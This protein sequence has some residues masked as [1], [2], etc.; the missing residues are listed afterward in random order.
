MCVFG[1]FCVVERGGVLAACVN[2]DSIFLN[3]H[4]YHLQHN[5]AKDISLT[6]PYVPNMMQTPC[7]QIRLSGI[8]FQ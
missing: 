1:V 5:Y 8:I 4:V 7:S 2:L 3:E 6:Q